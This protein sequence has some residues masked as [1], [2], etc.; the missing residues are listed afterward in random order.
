MTKHTFTIN[1]ASFADMV[2]RDSYETALVPVYG[3]E[4]TTL[5]GVAHR[6]VLR[7]RGRLTVG[8]NPAKLPRLKA[9]CAAVAAS[10]MTVKYRCLQR[11]Q[12][13]TAIMETDDMAA[14]FLSRVLAGSADWAAP[15]ALTLTEL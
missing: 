10:P 9:L 11:N 1:G 4:V 12:D 3:P 5:D 8:L 7:H 14:G 6:P 13:V 2:E 15:A